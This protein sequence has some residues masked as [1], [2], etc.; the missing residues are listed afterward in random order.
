MCV[1]EQ[2]GGRRT[3]TWNIGVSPV[4]FNGSTMVNHELALNKFL[5][6]LYNI[7]LI[8]SEYSRRYL[9]EFKADFE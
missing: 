9:F 6:C 7:S 4:E 5:K 2:G 1:S 3:V 8:G